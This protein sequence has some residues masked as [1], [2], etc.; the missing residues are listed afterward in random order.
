MSCAIFDLGLRGGTRWGIL[1]R[2][3]YSDTGMET[4]VFPAPHGEGSGGEVQPRPCTFAF[5]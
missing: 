5:N 1:H 2:V 4:A 3:L